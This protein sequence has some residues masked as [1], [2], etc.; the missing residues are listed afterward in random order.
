MTVDS[1]IFICLNIVQIGQGLAINK[2]VEHVHP[3]KTR[4]AQ[5]TSQ[6]TYARMFTEKFS[7]RVK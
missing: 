3:L 4:K 1:L 2:R 6:E 7:T 5:G